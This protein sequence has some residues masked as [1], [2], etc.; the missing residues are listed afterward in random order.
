MEKFKEVSL[1]ALF[2]VGRVLKSAEFD[3]G[4]LN[5][6]TIAVGA[7]YCPTSSKIT[8]GFELFKF[9]FDVNFDVEA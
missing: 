4:R 1:K 8:I 9:T 7:N 3:I 2:K 6:Y 5:W